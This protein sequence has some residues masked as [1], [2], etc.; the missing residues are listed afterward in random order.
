MRHRRPR[1][2]GSIVRTLS[3][4]I[5]L[6]LGGCATTTPQSTL[7]IAPEVRSASQAGEVLFRDMVGAAGGVGFMDRVLYPK[8]Q[9]RSVVRIEVVSPYVGSQPGVERWYIEHY[10]TDTAT[11]LITLIPDGKGGT[12]FSTIREQ[13]AQH[14]GPE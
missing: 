12:Y 13:P 9:Q 6:L 2:N 14:E 5:G 8:A 11:Y 3:F 7:S 10:G 1:M 4:V